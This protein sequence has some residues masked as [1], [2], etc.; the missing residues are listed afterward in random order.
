MR[1]LHKKTQGRTLLL[2]PP[3]AE[4]C[5]HA[6]EQLS[7]L[8]FLAGR[9]SDVTPVFR[10]ELCLQHDTSLFAGTVHRQAHTR[11]FLI[12]HR[13]RRIVYSRLLVLLTA[14]ELPAN[15]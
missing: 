11:N 1:L 14:S 15:G 8:L 13:P 4:N 10:L 12:E 7:L 6:A 2:L 3:G 5:S 9:S